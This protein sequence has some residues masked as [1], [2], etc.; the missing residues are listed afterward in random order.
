MSHEC[1]KQEIISTI[2]KDIE[3]LYA[4]KDVVI[5]LKTLVSMQSEQNKKQDEILRQQ[6]EVLIKITDSVSQQA[7]VLKKLSEKYEELDNK[8]IQ[9][10]FD[11]LKENSITFNYII[12]SLIDKAIPPIV[13]AGL[14][15]LV[16]E[17][18][19]KG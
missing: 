15:Y 1:Q 11:E 17:V 16:L 13:I 14:T 19:K 18:V 3:N 5:Q 2:R 9:K 10:N 4:V 6:S 8:F 7:E 12:K